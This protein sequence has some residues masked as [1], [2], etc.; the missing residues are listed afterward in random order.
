MFHHGQSGV[1][2]GLG[3]GLGFGF[4][5]F[6]VGAPVGVALPV[7]PA[8]AGADRVGCTPPPAPAVVRTGP[9]APGAEA[10]GGTPAVPVAPELRPVPPVFAAPVAAFAEPEAEPFPDGSAEGAAGAPV[11]PGS[12]AGSSGP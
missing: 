5:P 1:G 3:F 10:D 11:R 7:G 8:V 9:G 2:V 4:G 6:E 12:G